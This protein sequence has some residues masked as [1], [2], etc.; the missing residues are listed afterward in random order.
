MGQADVI[1][2]R[3]AQNDYAAV[4][5]TTSSSGKTDDSAGD[6]HESGHEDSDGGTGGSSL[7]VMQRLRPPHQT[8]SDWHM[9]LTAGNAAVVLLL[10]VAGLRP[11]LHVV[12]G[13][14]GHGHG[15]DLLQRRPADAG[16]GYRP[17]G[18]RCHGAG[19]IH[20]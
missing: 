16:L 1:E 14:H 6:H 20:G 10:A 7:R 12:V 11:D 17:R 3:R 19:A 5:T 9:W 13:G 15:R 2:M 18:P 8:L 4:N